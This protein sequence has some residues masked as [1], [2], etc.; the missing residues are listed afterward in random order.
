MGETMM[1]VFSPPLLGV[2]P[3]EICRV[4]YG[5]YSH[6]SAVCKSRAFWDLLDL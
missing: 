2:E 1:R 5:A 6:P 3:V 4:W